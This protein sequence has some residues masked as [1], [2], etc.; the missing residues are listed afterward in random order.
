M[1]E[2]APERLRARSVEWPDQ[3][4][5]SCALEADAGVR[6][7]FRANRA[8]LL[9]WP[10]PQLVGVASLKALALN[11]GVV[12]LALRVWGKTC[13]YPKAMAIDWLKREALNNKTS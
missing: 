10:S 9:A 4:E 5:L 1:T 11:V 7:S 12:K 8:Q 2:A 6:E 3:D 13:D